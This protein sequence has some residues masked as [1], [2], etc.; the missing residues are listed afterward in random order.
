MRQIKYKVYYQHGETGRIVVKIVAFGQ[1][2]P[3]LGEGY[4]SHFAICEYTG[5]KDSK[6]TEIWEG[7]I[8]A[9]ENE[10]DVLTVCKW[11][12]GCFVLVDNAGG[13]WTRQLI[14]QPDRLEIIGNI[15]EDKHLLND[16]A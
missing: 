2:I 9:V 8:V 16:K 4:G 6:G 1:L 13:H 10:G 12:K 15:H 5:L 11:D 3:I 14:Y 7:D